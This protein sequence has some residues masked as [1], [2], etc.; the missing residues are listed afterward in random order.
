MK[1]FE[2]VTPDAIMRRKNVERHTGLA[3]STIAK[4]ISIGDFPKP[5]RLTN[6]AVGWRTSAVEAW[7][8]S[9]AQST[10]T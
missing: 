1:H 3:R 7:L 9:R 10:S 4:L 8:A 2:E 6:R 5:I